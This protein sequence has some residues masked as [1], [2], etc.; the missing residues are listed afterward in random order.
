M[1]EMTVAE[2]IF[3]LNKS[4]I[5]SNSIKKQIGTLVEQQARDIDHAKATINTHSEMA[6]HYKRRAEQA[7]AENKRLRVCCNCR[8]FEWPKCTV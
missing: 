4:T 1:A 2:A 8:H 7:E 6:E 5:L 3:V